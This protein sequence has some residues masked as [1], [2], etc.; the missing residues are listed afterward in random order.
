MLFTVN[1]KEFINILSK[2]K[3]ILK[4]KGTLIQ[5]SIRIE[6]FKNHI[7]FKGTNTET[8]FIVTLPAT[9]EITGSVICEKSKLEKM[10]KKV[11]PTEN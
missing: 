2:A 1:Q 5:R 4:T 7:Q 11:K 9:V 3:K 8:E 6:A 10:A